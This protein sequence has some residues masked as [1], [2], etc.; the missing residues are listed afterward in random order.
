MNVDR[1]FSITV[2][3]VHGWELDPGMLE[4]V[5]RRCTWYAQGVRLID[6]YPQ[7]RR[8]DGFLEWILRVIG[9]HGALTIG[10]VQRGP[11]EQYEFHS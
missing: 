3:N 1:T 11:S 4:A 6:V 7:E 2:H 9:P 8:P 10:V 5:L